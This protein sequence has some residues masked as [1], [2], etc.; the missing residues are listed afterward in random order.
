MRIVCSFNKLGI[1]AQYWKREIEAASDAE[2]TFIP[3][4]HTPY[5]N[6][7]RYLEAWQLDRLY[8]SGS[9]ELRSMY[10]DLRAVVRDMGADA[11]IVNN[12][13]PYHPE[14]LKDLNVYRVLNSSDD[15][16]STYRRNIPYLHAYHHVLF[17][18]P[19][20]SADLDMQQK[21]RYCGMANA[22][23]CPLGVMDFEM[24]ANATEDSLARQDRDIEVVYVGSFFRQKLPL[25]AE[26]KR[27]MGRRV[28]IYGWYKPKHMAYFIA[29]H[30]YPGW[31]RS[32]SF[33]ERRSLY[34]RARIGFNIHWNEYGL[35][36]QRLYHLPANGVMQISDC[37]E[38]LHR[39]FEVGREIEAYRNVDELID[40]LRF[41]L[42][43]P[44]ER[45]RIALAGFRRTMKEY[46]FGPLLRRAAD[47]IGDGMRRVGWTANDGR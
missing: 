40:K 7:Y 27:A 2:H 45:E 28:R 36:N 3:F 20:Y 25:I 38:H 30:G 10:R 6:P 5:L 9:S 19:V 1:E 15:P 35:G 24:D 22:D 37:A 42:A 29:R 8:R 18:D 11:L 39:V 34:Q 26:V 16:D 46:R 13:P 47:L 33:D 4:D 14:F 44:E 21:M 17:A 32:V 12:C 31:I 43:R 41:Y 23:W